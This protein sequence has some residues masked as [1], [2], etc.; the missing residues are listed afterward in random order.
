[1]AIAAAPCR[2]A[3]LAASMAEAVARLWCP[4]AASTADRAHGPSPGMIATSSGGWSRRIDSASATS[5]SSASTSTSSAVASVRKSPSPACCWTYASRSG[6]TAPAR[7]PW[8]CRFNPTRSG[9]PRSLASASAGVP[10]GRLGQLRPEP[11]GLSR[12]PSGDPDRPRQPVLHA[13][14]QPGHRDQ[15]V[16]QPGPGGRHR[17]SAKRVEQ[18][19]T[20]GDRLRPAVGEGQGS[21]QAGEGADPVRA[22]RDRRPG[23]ARPAG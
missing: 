12:P 19:L 9:Q 21:G 7:S 6:S 18:L 14:E 20:D 22:G 8:R 23:S 16:R 5:P 15:R 3:I 10:Q 17:V 2:A 11:F 1:M 4:V 13:V